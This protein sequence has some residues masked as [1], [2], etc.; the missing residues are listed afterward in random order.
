VT[1]LNLGLAYECRAYVAALLKAEEDFETYAALCADIFCATS[2]RALAAKYARLVKRARDGKISV[3][4]SILDAVGFMDEEMLI[5]RIDSMMRSCQTLDDRAARALTLL[6]EHAGSA[7]GVLYLMGPQGPEL[8]ALF[9][10]TEIPPELDAMAR[11]YLERQIES[12]D[13]TQT[14]SDGPGESP[15]FWTDTNGQYYKTL[16]LNHASQEGFAITGLALLSV[17]TEHSFHHPGE[18]VT[19]LSRYAA[20]RGDVSVCVVAH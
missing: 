6:A 16:L 2:N 19:C 14:G 13:R 3:A 4:K 5:S 7:R 11:A 1:G 9:G 10:R 17:Q 15:S 8:K 12:D 20:E 18:L